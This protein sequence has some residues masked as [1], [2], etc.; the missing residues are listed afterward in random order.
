MTNGNLKTTYGSNLLSD[1]QLTVTAAGNIETEARP[2]VKTQRSPS[3]E[4]RLKSL[5]IF[6]ATILCWFRRK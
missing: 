5:A 1:N 4:T 2:E 6:L 3:E